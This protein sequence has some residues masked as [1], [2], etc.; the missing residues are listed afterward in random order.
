LINIKIKRD[1]NE[2]AVEFVVLG[3]SGCGS[4]GRDIIC[5][6]VSAVAFNAINAVQ[7][8][9]QVNVKYEI[10]D[11]YMRV[12]LPENLSH[13]KIQTIRIIMETIIVGFKQ[14]Q[15]DNER[16]IC[17]KEEVEGHDKN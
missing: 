16:Y 2:V 17:I 15:Q 10:D 13:A 6:A 8:I 11:G 5:A 12:R 14:I 3:H 7:E 9:A 4:Q 1:K